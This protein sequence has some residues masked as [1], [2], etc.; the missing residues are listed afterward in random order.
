MHYIL[1]YTAA[2][3]TTEHR[4]NNREQALYWLSWSEGGHA[5][6]WHGNNCESF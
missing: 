5:T 4:F 3:V 2:G 1:V 6:L